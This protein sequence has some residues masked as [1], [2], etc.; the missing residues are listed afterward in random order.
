MSTKLI[1]P[2]SIAL[3]QAAELVQEQ[4][5]EIEKF[6]I[7][8]LNSDDALVI[9]KQLKKDI[10]D[11][12]PARVPISSTVYMQKSEEEL[13]RELDDSWRASPDR[14]GGQFTDQ[15]IKDDLEKW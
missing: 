14:M 2:T 8:E 11:R 15:E 10:L 4:I 9:L 5:N 1:T 12:K 7:I 6:D 13:N 3:D